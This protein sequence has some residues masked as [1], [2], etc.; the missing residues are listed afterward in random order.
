MDTRINEN[1]KRKADKNGD[2]VDNVDEIENEVDASA[3]PKR[4]KMDVQKVASLNIVSDEMFEH[5][6]S[7][8]HIKIVFPKFLQKE[9]DIYVATGKPTDP[10]YE[11][12]KFDL[13]H[14]L[15]DHFSADGSPS[16]SEKIYVAIYIH[17]MNK[18]SLIACVSYFLCNFYEYPFDNISLNFITDKTMDIHIGALTTQLLINDHR[19][20]IYKFNDILLTDVQNLID[21]SSLKNLINDSAEIKKTLYKFNF[22]ILHENLLCFGIGY[23]RWFAYEHAKESNYEF[24]FQIDGT[25]MLTS[26]VNICNKCTLS[27]VL[28]KTDV[29]ESDTNGAFNISS[30]IEDFGWQKGQTEKPKGKKEKIIGPLEKYKMTNSDLMEYYVRREANT[31]KTMKTKDNP[32]LKIQKK[33]LLQYHIFLVHSFLSVYVQYAANY[34]SDNYEKN[35]DNN[36]AM[37]ATDRDANTIGE[38]QADRCGYDYTISK[39]YMTNMKVVSQNPYN[40]YF[41]KF[42]EDYGATIVIARNNQKIYKECYNR[43]IKINYD[44]IGNNPFVNKL[45]NS[46]FMYADF[47][48]YNFSIGYFKLKKSIK[49]AD[50]VPRCVSYI[51]FNIYEA[52]KF[53]FTQTPFTVTKCPREPYKENTVLKEISNITDVLKCLKNVD[54]TSI[55]H[56]IAKI[57]LDDVGILPADPPL[58]IKNSS[59]VRKCIYADF[60]KKNEYEYNLVENF[61]K[62]DADYNMLFTG[63]HLF[64]ILLL[65]KFTNIIV[66][67][68]YYDKVVKLTHDYC[69]LLKLQ[70]TGKEYSLWI[71]LSSNIIIGSPGFELNTGAVSFNE[72]KFNK[73]EK[74]LFS[75]PLREFLANYI[76]KLKLKDTIVYTFTPITINDQ[77]F[78]VNEQTTLIKL[79]KEIR[80]YLITE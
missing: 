23:K 19:C 73:L 71:N 72:I 50:I 69:N 48:S 25:T 30:Q 38:G 14:I 5:D 42:I 22:I 46:I 70:Q 68:E 26:S 9:K 74:S 45:S 29:C 11:H 78:N 47:F 1:R 63:F 54:V 62:Y 6:A 21:K 2:A 3:R 4:P 80:E 53:L 59:Y 15:G 40:K 58:L 31:V 34:L 79:M 18:D 36:I 77:A 17:N 60:F 39:M 13:K 49:W 55:I 41:V 28:T 16:F 8:A 76:E 61:G 12:S 35:R 44:N 52:D 10:K 43:L 56:N 20:N 66:T 75:S 65:L 33:S 37:F 24:L 27:C 7:H 57:P 67:Q 64:I 51:K 32:A